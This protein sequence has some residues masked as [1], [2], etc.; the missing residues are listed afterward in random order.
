MSA[1][2]YSDCR[3]WYN[4]WVSE[5]AKGRVL[6]V[7]KSKFWYYGFP[8]IDIN[9]KMKPTY[10]GDIEKAPFRDKTFDTVL[11]NG[12]YEVVNDPQKMIDEILRITIDMAIFGFVGK[13]YKPYRKDW[14]YYR[15]DETIPYV[16]YQKNF[17]DEYYFILCSKR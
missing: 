13:D 12:M 7:G 5:N 14:K 3:R 1:V 17:G 8:T 9:P 4:V 16:F 2:E 11:C 6:D 10:V 15:G